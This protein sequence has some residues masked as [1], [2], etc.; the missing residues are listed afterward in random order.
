MP[1]IEEQVQVPK[2][3]Q[4]KKESIWDYPEEEFDD[5]LIVCLYSYYFRIYVLGGYQARIES[6]FFPILIRCEYSSIDL[7]NQMND[8]KENT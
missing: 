8:S 3:E 4:E 6:S 1:K 7:V 5:I 2:I